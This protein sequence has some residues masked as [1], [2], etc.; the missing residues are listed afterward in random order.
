MRR[1][2]DYVKS[3]RSDQSGLRP[4]TLIL[5]SLPAG[6]AIPLTSE[7]LRALP[8]QQYPCHA[9]ANSQSLHRDVLTSSP[10]GSNPPI[11]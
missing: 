11:F 3:S 1:V 5:F 10:I 4:V 9:T 2:V 8:W 7:T 6:I